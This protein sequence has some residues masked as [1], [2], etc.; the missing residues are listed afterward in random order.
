MMC[1]KR[2]E[3]VTRMD[4]VRNEEV[5]EAPRQEAVLEVVKEK[6]GKWNAKSE[7]M[8]ENRLVKKVYT[9]EA[10]RKRPQGR[11]RKKWQDNFT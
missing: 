4:R 5:R 9:D 7:Q 11:P 8:S 2:V 1:L 3:G 6:Q 10:R